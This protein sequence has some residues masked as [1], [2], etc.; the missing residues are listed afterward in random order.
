MPL[1]RGTIVA[2]GRTRVADLA[3]LPA[4]AFILR[5]ERGITY[6]ASLPRVLTL[7]AGEL[8]ASRLRGPAAGLGGGRAGHGLVLRSAMR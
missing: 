1:L 4:D 5:G 8:V 3:Q 7:T 2:Y 6:A